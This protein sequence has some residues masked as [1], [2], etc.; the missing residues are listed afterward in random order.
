MGLPVREVL[1]SK[2]PSPVQPSEEV[3]HGG[4]CG[5]KNAG[6]S[7]ASYILVPPPGPHLPAP[8]TGIHSI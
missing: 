8:P 4:K 5:S 3:L 7:G 1:L 6:C 2:H